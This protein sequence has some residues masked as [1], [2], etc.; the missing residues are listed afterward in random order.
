MTFWRERAGAE[1][2]VEPPTLP[3]LGANADGEGVL[4]MGADGGPGNGAN[5][6]MGLTLSSASAVSEAPAAAAVDDATG[7]DA[8]PAEGSV[9][10]LAYLRAR[11]AAK[12]LCRYA[13]LRCSLLILASDGTH[14]GCAWSP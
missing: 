11:L 3:P 5:Q 6:K 9:S 10:R 1:T 12:M 13:A 7:A 4:A 2:T 14:T 8:P